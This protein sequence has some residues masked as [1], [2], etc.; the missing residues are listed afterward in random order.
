MP[1]E[2]YDT[3][4]KRAASQILFL[5]DKP[6]ENPESTV[7]S[8][9][10]CATGK[11]VSAESAMQLDMP[12]LTED[13]TVIFEAL[14]E[15]RKSGTPLSHIIGFQRFMGIDFKVSSAALI[16]RKET[17]ILGNAVLKLIDGRTENLTILDVC[18]GMGNLALTVAYYYKNCS[19]YA[20][21]I[22]AEAVKLAEENASILQL[23]DRVK[24][25]TGDLFGPLPAEK[26]KNAAD[27]I[28]CNP[29]YISKQ[30][31]DQLPAEIQKYEPKEAFDGGSFGISIVQ[32][33]INEARKFLKKDAWLCFEV[34]LGQGEFFL[35]KPNKIYSDVSQ[36]PDSNGD[37]RVLLAK[38]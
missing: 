12:V 24:F 18:T 30:K 27:I 10:L 16:P 25:Y 26:L 11:H 19:V 29:P 14:F 9:F 7:R 17:E 38:Y 34:G 1:Y 2:L 28:I 37:I 13:Q 35:N 22:S 15:K 33:L 23:A 6:E 8:L 21:D 31:L 36:V 5:P 20:A 3:Y 32:R 4:V